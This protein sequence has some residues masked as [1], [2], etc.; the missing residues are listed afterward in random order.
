VQIEIDDPARPDVTALLAEHLAD[1]HATSPAESVH[2]LDVAALKVPG[3]TFWTARLDG[4]LLGCGA[5]KE[6]DATH[7]ELKS[8][9]TTSV[10]RGTGVGRAMLLHLVEVGRGRGYSRLSLETGTQ[11][12]F[13]PARTLYAAHGFTPCD[14]FADYRED[15]YSA[16]FTLL[17]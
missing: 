3:L 15:P 8:M 1:M 14:P 12:Y 2:A 5:L 17:V 7:G 9:R 6:L 13:L 11:D 4:L 10:S 16:Y